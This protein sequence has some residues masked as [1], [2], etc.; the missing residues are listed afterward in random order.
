MGKGIRRI[1]LYTFLLISSVVELKAQTIYLHEGFELGR[2][3]DNWTEEAV[4]GSVPWR[5]RNGGYNPSDPNLLTDPAAYDRFR[6]PDTA[7]EGTYNS[8]F[9]TQGFGREQTKLITPPLDFSFAVA[10]TL[11]FW[12]TVCEWR[13]PTGVNNDILRI[14]YKVGAKGGWRILQTYNF[15]QNSWCDFQLSL[16]PEALQKDVYL[17]FEGLS[18]WGM[19]ICLDEISIKET[20]NQAK[21]IT[22]AIPAAVTSEVI[23]NGTNSN[24]ILCTKLKVTGNTGDA[25]LDNVK[26]NAIATKATDISRVRLYV[27]EYPEFNASVQIAEGVLTGTSTTLKPSYKLPTGY[28]YL[29]VAYDIA[30]TSK[31]GNTVDAEIPASGIG[32]NGITFANATINP[33]GSRVLK[34]NLFFDDFETDKGWV[35]SGDFEIATPMGKLAKDYGNADPA[36]AFSGTKVLGNDL[37]KDG[38]YD[39]NIPSSA[40]YTATSPSFDALYYKGLVLNIKRWLNVDMFDTVKIQA[41]RNNG[42]TWTTLWQNDDYALD[43]SWNS[44]SVAFPAEFDRAHD[45]KLRF[46]LSYTS[47]DREFTG[48]NIDDVSVTGTFMEKDLAM[49]EIVSPTSTCGTATNTHPITVRVKNAGSKEAVAPIPVKL[50]IKDGQTIEDNITENIAP[51]AEAVVT[52]TKPFPANLYGDMEIKAQTFLPDDED[53]TNDATTTSV[54]ISKTYPVPYSNNFDTPDDWVKTGYNWMHGISTAPNILGENATDKMWITNLNGNYD[55]SAKATLTSPCFDIVGLQK[56]MLEFNT[57]Y[58]TELGKDGV[59]LS[60]SADNGKTWQ[61]VGNNNDGWD[62]YWGWDKQSTIASSGK[63]GFTGNSNGWITISHL[64]PASLNEKTGIKFRF[65]FTSDAQN[66]LFSGFGLNSFSIKEAPDDFGISSIV[67]PVTLTGPETCGGFTDKENII[68]KVKNYGI[69]MAK[70]DAAVKVTFKSEYAQKIGDPISRTEVFEEAYTLPNDLA[71]GAEVQLTTTKTIDMNR[72]GIYNI[73]VVNIDNPDK[74]YKTDNDKIAKQVQVNKPVVDLGPTVMLGDPYPTDPLNPNSHI[75]DI[76]TYAN[77]FNYDIKW[78]KK[79]GDGAWTLLANNGYIQSILKSEFV[80]PNNKITFKVTLT[81]KTPAHCSVSSIADVYAL[82]P[83]I[84]VTSIVSPTSTCSL[85]NKQAVTVSITNQGK[86]IDVIKAGTIISLQL[87]VNTGTLSKETF[88]ATK[89]IASGEVFQYTFPETFDMSAK[90]DYAI[91]AFASIPFDV[92]INDKFASANSELTKIKSFGFPAFTLMPQTQTVTAIDYTYDADPDPKKFSSYKWHDESTLNTNKV[93]FPGPTGGKLWCTVTDNNKCSTKSE[94]TITF[95]IKDIAVKSTS[96]I[97]TACTHEPTMKPALTIENKGNVPLLNGT[98]IPFNITK[99]GVVT[100]CDY[101]LTATLAPAAVLDITLNTPLDMSA[102]GDYTVTIEAKLPGDLVADNNTLSATIKTYGLPISSLPPTV[103]SHDVEVTLDAG[104]GF[105]DYTW[106][107]F[108][109]DQRIVVSKSGNFKVKITDANLCSSTY[110]TD[111]LFIRNDLSVDLT[112]TYGTASTICSGSSEYP[113]TINITNTGNDTPK[114]GTKI[115]VSYKYGS[116]EVHEEFTLLE[117]LAPATS[118][119]YSFTKK[120]VFTTAQPVAISAMITLD[121]ADLT[122]NFTKIVNITVNQTPTVSLGPDVNTS[123]ASYTIIPTVTPPLS[124]YK[125]LWNTATTATVLSVNKSGTYSLTVN[126]QGCSASDEVLVSFNKQDISMISV[127]SPT[128]RCFATTDQDVAVTFKNTGYEPVIAGTKITLSYVVGTFNATEDITLNTDFAVGATQK[129]TFTKKVTALAAATY[130]PTATAF[131]TG[132]GVPANNT[133][134]GSFTIKPLPTISLPN[135][136]MANGTQVAISGPDG[137]TKYAWSTGETT[138][139]ITVNK[140]GTYTLSVTDAN[141][142]SNTKST[143]VLFTPDIELVSVVSTDICQNPLAQPITVKI[144]NLSANPIANGT[145]LT[146]SGKIN[147]V[148]FTEVQPL[149]SALASLATASITLTK[150]LPNSVT[151]QYPFEVEVKVPNEVNLSNNSKT[152]TITVNPSPVFDLPADM[153]STKNKETI[154]GPAGMASYLWSNGEK[155][156]SIT[157]TQSGTYT[158]KVTNDKGCPTEKSISVKFKGG[159]IAL[160]SIANSAKLCSGITTPLT[161]VVGNDGLMAI[162]KGETINVSIKIDGVATTED[163]VLAED[164]LPQA[165]TTITLKGGLPPST[166]GKTVTAEVSVTFLYDVNSSNATASKTFVV[167]ASPTFSVDIKTVTSK[168]EATLTA[169]KADLTYVWSTKATSKAITVYENSVYKVIGTNTD[170][171]SLTKDVSVDF[172]ISSSNN[173]IMVYPVVSQTK[174]YEGIKSPF[175]VK[176]VNESLNTIV[177]IGTDVKVSCTYQIAKTNGTLAEYKFSGTTKI[178]NALTPGNFATYR[179]TNMVVQGKTI[180]NILEENA[181]KQTVSGFT[182][183][184]SKPSTTK[185][186]QFEIYPIPVVD[187]GNEIIYRPLPGVLKVNLSND[188]SFTWSTGQKNISSIIISE[189]GKYWV[190]VTSKAGCTASDTVT[191]KKGSEDAKLLINIY[192]N[193]ASSTVN[194]EAFNTDNVDITIDLYSSNGT[195]LESRLFPTTSQAVMLNYDI[196]RLE[197]GTYAVVARTKDKKIAKILV[198]TR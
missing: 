127:D 13:I 171:C 131:Y 85:G 57:S 152:V 136:T 47:S 166:V 104:P 69:K 140:E 178:S 107:T 87:R 115:P 149:G 163:F 14:Y 105:S 50:Y 40:P 44:F 2:K 42:V 145:V 133:A 160:K 52:L 174:C 164:L 168:S 28:T 173:Y 82:N 194:F 126:N 182:E 123:E 109:K 190:S 15:V 141:G 175:E 88:T 77:G 155:T 187:L 79:V 121:D 147:G 143:Q 11:A 108:E 183:V 3:P 99:N 62:T 196:S 35:L 110:S 20:G 188:Y 100:T 56:P 102:K 76:T 43:D 1:V 129:Y 29:W 154:D 112:S 78:E 67:K 97:I 23:P 98:I 191:V 135:P 93:V 38:L 172:L 192:P 101:T 22:E 34:Q 157:V 63:V 106:S 70:K 30:P 95:A 189:E 74:F 54:Y 130:A 158:L 128:D 71:V 18:R 139:A 111:V 24:P 179:F 184:N 151:E 26:V 137:M 144:K 60:Y 116:T 96:N 176:L 21:T 8:W 66:N 181:G 64:L 5:Y 125:Y 10:P 167:V 12:L 27:T 45:I 68:F 193:P 118:I 134:T 55:N 46:A 94:A 170:G 122:N 59:T 195:L 17:A 138:Q 162:S 119:S 84:A 25:I 83:D 73:T 86:D 197:S 114:A 186:T 185:T 39:A 180:D 48:W 16:P 161:L 58:I 124:T 41:T 37:T 113:V 142:C 51:G 80:S 92:N 91:E 146:F 65:E 36:H 132:D 75:F 153:V 33:I 81:D 61:L 19:G 7:K 6:N 31:S 90:G 9:F 148:D 89:D 169:S 117:D 32:V 49:M 72:G 53:I 156:Q 177:P 150:S 198:V 103:V 120:A 159:D 4:V 165:T